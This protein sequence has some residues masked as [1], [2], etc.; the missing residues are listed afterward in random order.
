MTKK[1]PK[2]KRMTAAE[3]KWAQ[4]FRAEMRAKGL[5]PPKK[6]PLNR[7][8]FLQETFDQWEQ[9]EDSPLYYL[10]K[11][12]GCM[13]SRNQSRVT[14]EEV[15]VLKVMKLALEI[16]AFE[17]RLSAEGKTS[18]NAAELYEQVLKPVLDL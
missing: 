7:K 14:A 17:K 9:S 10:P 3:K 2:P 8:R 1:K 11:A 5:I 4:E 16:Q 12:I 15:G 13:V 18:Y 6:Q